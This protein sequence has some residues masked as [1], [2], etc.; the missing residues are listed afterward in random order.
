MK[1]KSKELIPCE[2]VKLP[3]TPMSTVKEKIHTRC[4]RYHQSIFPQVEEYGTKRWVVCG[5]L[6]I[7][8]P[9][10][11]KHMTESQIVDGCVAFLNTPP[12]RKRNPLYGSLKPIPALWR[13][14]GMYEV[15]FMENEFVVCLSTTERRNKNFWGDGL[16]MHLKP[17]GRS[18]K[19]K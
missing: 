19:K 4:G 8:E 18:K 6:K 5:Y 9:E 12:P 2:W 17:D 10:K 11:F 15:K 7:K 3:K 1:T 16:T 13:G 14:K